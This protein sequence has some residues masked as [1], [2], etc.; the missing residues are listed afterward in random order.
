[1]FS[2]SKIT[3]VTE[4]KRE[5]T[6][7]QG[8][9]SKLIKIMWNKAH[10]FKSDHQQNKPHANETE[11]SLP[12]MLL[13]RRYQ[14]PTYRRSPLQDV[15]EKQRHENFRHSQSETSAE[16]NTQNLYLKGKVPIFI[17]KEKKLSQ[18]K[19]QRKKKK[20][21]CE[22]KTRT[23][24]KKNHLHLVYFLKCLSSVLNPHHPGL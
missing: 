15:I 17:C 22:I 20:K 16:L 21:L 23:R 2:W 9:T 13:T 8:W 24:L 10:D 5:E 19:R 11:C 14:K 1:M 18:K 6:K 7:K 3:S 12:P 4:R